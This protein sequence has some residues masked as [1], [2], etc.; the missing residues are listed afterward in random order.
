MQTLAMKKSML[1]HS[2]YSSY[3]FTNHAKTFIRALDKVIIYRAM[4]INENFNS[5]MY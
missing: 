2:V 1:F 3:I 5:N 4:I